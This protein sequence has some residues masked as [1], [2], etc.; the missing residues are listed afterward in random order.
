MKK[1]LFI[2]LIFISPILLS[3][4]KL[5]IKIDNKDWE[6][7]SISSGIETVMNMTVL[8]IIGQLE[9]ERLDISV[10]YEAIKGKD[11]ANFIFQENFMAPPGGVSISYAPK[12]LG[13]QQWV[14]SKGTISYFDFEETNNTVSGKFKATL[15]QMLDDNG[16]FVMT[17]PRPEMEISGE[18]INIKFT[19]NSQNQEKDKQ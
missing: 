11:S 18:F 1:A 9:K 6:P 15:T 16:G 3:Q 8:E 7:Q 19:N 5:N 12:G 4:N 10:D 13:R 14:T 17:T 2:L